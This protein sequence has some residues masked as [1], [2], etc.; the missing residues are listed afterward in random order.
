MLMLV[1]TIII[2]AVVSGYAG[3]LIGNTQKSPTLAM[4]VRIV[5]TGT[6]IGSGFFASV[7]GAS[8]AISTKDTK[9]V[10]QWKTTYRSNG[11]ALMGGNVSVGGVQNSYCY[12]GMKTNK[13]IWSKVPYGFGKGAG[14]VSGQN[15]TNPQTKPNQQFGNYSLIQGTSLS[16]TPYGTTSGTAI[17]GA[18]GLSDTSGYGVVTPYTYSTGGNYTA[19]Q[20]DATQAVLG[21]NWENLKPGDAVSVKVVYI[22]SGQTIYQ[23]TVSVTEG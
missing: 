16:A 11:T 13:A 1:V 17:G 9:L 20:F 10:T 2:A 5:N 21:M 18:P 19:D 12:I 23:K 6:W 14:D 7:T 22:P 3:G 4:D 15:P 8:D